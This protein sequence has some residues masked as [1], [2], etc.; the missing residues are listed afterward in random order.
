MT[1]TEQQDFLDAGSICVVPSGWGRY[2][3]IA[4]VSTTWMGRG[5]TQRRNA[6]QV[7]EGLPPWVTKI[8]GRNTK[9][10]RVI[11]LEFCGPQTRICQLMTVYWLWTTG[12]KYRYKILR[13]ECRF[14]FQQAKST[15][16]C[17]LQN[18]R[19]S[20]SHYKAFEVSRSGCLRTRQHHN[21]QPTAGKF[22]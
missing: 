5:G 8:G 9:R 19:V 14:D 16:C 3:W 4:A 10:A 1:S 18:P 11:P 21:R 22:P 2:W 20:K 13:E 15:Y 7:N 12:S 17:F 6:T